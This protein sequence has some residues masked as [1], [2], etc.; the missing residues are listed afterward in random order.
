MMLLVF[1]HDSYLGFLPFYRCCPL[2]A[3]TALKSLK[4][5][6][7]IRPLFSNKLH[8]NQCTNYLRRRKRQL[9]CHSRDLCSSSGKATL[10]FIFVFMRLTTLNEIFWF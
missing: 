7:A 2:L 3:L 6:N 1:L 8:P 4:S 10:L 5:Q 9:H